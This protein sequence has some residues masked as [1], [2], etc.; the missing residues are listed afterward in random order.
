MQIILYSNVSEPYR[1]NKKLTQVRELAGILREG[2]NLI[3]PEIKVQLDDPTN[4]NYAYI[5][6]FKR[7]YY[8]ND[9]IIDYN[10]IYT[11]T[12]QV[13]VLMSFKNQF[14]PLSGV[15]L[16]Q[17]NNYNDYLYDENIV[18]LQNM[19]V[20]VKT[21]E[22][23]GFFTNELQNILIVAGGYDQPVLPTE[24]AETSSD[25]TVNSDVLEE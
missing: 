24:T 1:V 6:E 9:V 23:S 16:R 5:P 20:Q 13:D 7:Y 22:K 4:F 10:N 3:A 18:G 11:L 12:L 25:S 14:L 8:V 17:E 2:S 19:Q 21:F 15:I